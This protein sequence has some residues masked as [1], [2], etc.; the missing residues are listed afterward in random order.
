[1]PS[2]ESMTPSS[3]LGQLKATGQHVLSKLQQQTSNADIIDIRRVAVEINLKTEITSMFRPK[4]GPRQLPTLL[5]YNERGLQLFERIT[6]LE[7]YYL[8]NDE[9]KILTKHATEMAS[10]I[11]SGAMII[12]LGSGNLRKVNLLLEA[13]DNA[14]KAIDYYALDL[15]REELERTLA[16]VPSY[17]HVK[18]HGLLGTYDD[19]R[20]WLKAPENINKQKCILHLGSSIGN[21]NRSDAATFLKGFTDVLGPNDKMLIG[22]DACNDPA[23]VYHAY[24]DKV[25]ITHEFILNGL[26]NANE[27]I[28]ETAFIEGDWRVIGE[29][30]YDEE[31]GRHQAFYAPTRDTMVMGELIRSHDRIQIEQSLKY[32]KEE[33]ERLWSTAGLEQV[34]EWTY[35]NEYGLHLLAKSRMSFSLIPSVYARSALPTLDDWEALWATW[36]VVTRQMLPQEELLEKP[37]KLRNACIFYLGHIPTF[38]DIQLTKT[39]KQAPSEPAHFCK[40]FERGIDPDVDNPELCHAHSEIPDEW[41]PVEEILTYQETVRSR[42]RGL[43]AHG[44]ANIPRNV[45]RAIWVGFEHELMHIETLLYMMLQSDKTLIPTHIPRPDFDKLAR[46]AESER[47]PNQWFKIPAQEIT[48]GL[49]DPEDG[50]DINKHYGWDN[51]K[52]PRRVQVAAFQ[53]QGRPITNEEYAQYLLEKNIDKL[54]ASWARLD[55]ENISNGTTNSVSGHHSNRTSKQQLPSSFLEKTAVRTVY[56]LV[57]LK[58]ALDWPVFASYDE[59]AG[60]AAYMGGRIP[61]FEETR[62]IYAYADALKKKKEAER[63]L[64]RTV[65]AVNAHLTNNGVEITPPSSPSSETPAESSSPSDS[66]TTLI[67]TEDLFSDLDGANVGFHNWHP[68]PITSKGNTL[69]G[70][71]ELGGVWEWTSSVL[72]KWEGFEPME[73][74][75]GYTADFFDEKHNIVLGGSWA[76]HPRIAGRKS[77]VN[78]YQRNYPYAWVGARVVRD[79]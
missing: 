51:E 69:V 15:S 30:V 21:F 27:I 22:V 8:T 47:V 32:S 71:G 53:A 70:Q 24:N 67:T 64:G 46:K 61:T 73:L 42:L 50:S 4:D 54:P 41:P 65:P 6:Y 33:S 35:G 60:C 34:S 12:E 57:P 56:G 5:L 63:Q 29:Y 38:L 17:K 45:G 78:W 11:P 9:I 62:S 75:P 43:Y 66:N 68:M 49:D 31:G 14:G 18:C 16:Q 76:T 48:I 13:L 7:E 10:F 59:L 19:G 77:F 37:I 1:M 72:R 23:R 26:R 36:D 55:N 28:G 74:Y 2:A 39:T 44:I 40:I 3:A 79:L 52:P 25:G 20:D 58:H